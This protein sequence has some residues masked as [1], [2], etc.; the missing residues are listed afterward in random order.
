VRR[1]VLTLEFQEIHIERIEQTQEKLFKWITKHPETMLMPTFSIEEPTS[2]VL[3]LYNKL[4]ST[5]KNSV[6][7]HVHIS[8][9]LYHSPPPPLQD[10]E[11]QYEIVKR[12]LEHLRKLG[13]ETKDFTSGNWNYNRDTFLVCRKLDLT[14]VHI[15]LKEIPKITSKYGIPE[16]ISLIPVVRHLH[17]YDI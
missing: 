4:I 10:Y 16:G 9:G 15:K 17:D 2:E 12:G 7:L 11:T 6:G 1:N 14:S 3:T 8:G 13:I 5:F